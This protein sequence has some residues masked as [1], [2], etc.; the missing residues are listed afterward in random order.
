MEA[1][2]GA[3]AGPSKGGLE[4]IGK[5]RRGGGLA[6]LRGERDTTEGEAGMGETREGGVRRR[7][8]GPGL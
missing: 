2:A 6:H 5:G 4:S 1:V 8:S 7:E 3:D